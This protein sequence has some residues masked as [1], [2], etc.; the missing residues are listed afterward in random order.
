M[1]TEL[2]VES[3]GGI[4]AELTCQRKCQGDDIE[5]IYAGGRCERQVLVRMLIHVYLICH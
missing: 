2:F 4:T 3:T 5:S 1:T